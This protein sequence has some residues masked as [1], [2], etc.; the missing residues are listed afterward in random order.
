MSTRSVPL[1]PLNTVLF[2][3]GPLAL[4]I[5]EQR[6]LRMVRDCLKVDSPFAVALISQGA[7]VGVAQTR[8]IGTLAAIVDWDRS[9]EGLLTIRARGQQRFRRVAVSRQRDGLYVAEVELL[10]AEAPVP[11][12]AADQDLIECVETL[13]SSHDEIYGSDT[14]HYDDATWVSYRLAETLPLPMSTRQA[15]LEI[16]DT[17]ERLEVLRP[18]AVIHGRSHGR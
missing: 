8:T 9:D 4:R 10:P 1:F 11:T 18:A 7:E 14:R 2:P 12:T 15:L 5:F 3:D 17:R 6:Y 16:D 13:L